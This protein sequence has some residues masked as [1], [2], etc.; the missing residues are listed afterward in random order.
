M[1][2]R[3]A[4]VSIRTVYRH[5]RTKRELVE[6]LTK[7]T[8]R[9]VGLADM[10][11]PRDAG[12]LAALVR[13]VFAGVEAMDPELRALYASELG[14]EMRRSVEL[15]ERHRMFAEALAPALRP[16]SETDRSH[17][18]NIVAVLASGHTL[19]AFKTDLGLSAEEAAESVG[20]AI[21]ALSRLA[22]CI[23]SAGDEAPDDPGG[24]PPRSQRKQPPRRPRTA[25]SRAGAQ[26]KG[27]DA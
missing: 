17:L 13:R 25:Q 3:E 16:L 8:N 9:R 4:G 11:Q 20:W 27:G 10:A 24:E 12:E 18:L 7:Y 21:R 14:Q 6:A 19:R 1:S 5:F 15:P 23:D 26:R 2:S 22:E